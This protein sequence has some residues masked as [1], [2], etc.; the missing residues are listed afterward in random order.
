[1][2]F[3]RLS[4]AAGAAKVDADTIYDTASLTKPVVTTTLAAML[5]EQGQ[6]DISAPVAV[7]CRNGR[8]G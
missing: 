3:G 7:T 8:A 1:M 4:N 6:L 2:R 5:C